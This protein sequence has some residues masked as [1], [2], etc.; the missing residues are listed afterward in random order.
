MHIN[1]VHAKNRSEFTDAYKIVRE[2]IEDWHGYEFFDAFRPVLT[3]YKSKSNVD[4]C[5]VNSYSN[6]RDEQIDLV[7]SN[8]CHGLISQKEKPVESIDAEK[9]I[10]E[11]HDDKPKDDFTDE[12]TQSE[13]VVVPLSKEIV[14][15]NKVTTDI[16]LPN[17]SVVDPNN[18]SSYVLNRTSSVNR[19]DLIIKSK[20]DLM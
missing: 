10:I 11:S 2:P 14:G 12:I 16:S 18:L 1:S 4:G 13:I 17:S 20:D 9:T 15:I 7:P 3:A 5:S 6:V 19:N 8:I